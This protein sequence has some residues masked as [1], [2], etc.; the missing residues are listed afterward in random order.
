[1]VDPHAVD[2]RQQ[3]VALLDHAHDLGRN[4]GLFGLVGLGGFFLEQPANLLAVFFF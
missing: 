2:D 3:Q 1:M 4:F